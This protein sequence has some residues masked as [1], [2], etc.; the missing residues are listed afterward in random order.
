MELHNKSWMMRIWVKAAGTQWLCWEWCWFSP[1]HWRHSPIH[2][3]HQQLQWWTTCMWGCCCLL[4]QLI[5]YICSGGVI[6]VD[7][8]YICGASS[9][10]MDLIGHDD[11]RTRPLLSVV[12]CPVA[13]N[14]WDQ[15]LLAL[16]FPCKVSA[17]TND[18][19]KQ[20]RTY[21]LR[22]HNE[23]NNVHPTIQ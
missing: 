16:I 2:I 5:W 22:R 8:D 11:P 18:S 12:S 23:I 15:S 10:L 1:R 20:L 9:P 14:T 13:A 17:L 6:D 3:F 7:G 4:H 19:L 21:Y